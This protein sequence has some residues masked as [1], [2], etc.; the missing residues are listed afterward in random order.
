MPALRALAERAA[1]RGGFQL[2]TDLSYTGRHPHEAL[3]LAGAREVLANAVTHADAE[4]VTM[5]LSESPQ[6]LTL[7]IEDDGVGFDRASLPARLAE[8][9]IGLQSQLE[10]V[11]TVG[12]RLEIRA[13]PGE[14]TTIRIRLPA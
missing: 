11:E 5:R 8:G 2:H 6:H 13:A 4:N 9:H 1:R 10:R 3:L 12:G 14:G 7:E